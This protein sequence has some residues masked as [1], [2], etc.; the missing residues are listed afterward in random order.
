M[1]HRRVLTKG[2]TLKGSLC[3]HIFFVFFFVSSFFCFRFFI[4]LILS[5]IIVVLGATHDAEIR[6]AR[7]R[8]DLCVPSR[9]IDAMQTPEQNGRL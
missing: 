9:A 4:I 6:H 2:P 5:L 3:D 8:H 7:L 1:P